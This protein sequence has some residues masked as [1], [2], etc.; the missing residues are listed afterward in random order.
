MTGQDYI[1]GRAHLFCSLKNYFYPLIGIIR[2][3]IHKNEL[4]VDYPF[5]R[6]KLPDLIPL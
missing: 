6:I 1:S 2:P 5:L 3:F 4:L